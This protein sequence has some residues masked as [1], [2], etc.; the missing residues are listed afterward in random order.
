M[1]KSK[2]DGIRVNACAS[3]GTI[4]GNTVL[5]SGERGIY[6]IG[7]EKS[8]VSGNTVTT[9]GKQKEGIYVFEAKAATIKGNVVTKTGGYGIRVQGKSS[10]KKMTAKMKGS[11]KIRME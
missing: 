7:S 6:V 3:G 11:R 4:S 8:T 1:T 5:N 2:T 9:T 10:S